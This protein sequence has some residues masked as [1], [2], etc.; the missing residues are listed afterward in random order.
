MFFYIPVFIALYFNVH[1]DLEKCFYIIEGKTF[2]YLLRSKYDLNVLFKV[3]NL[4]LTIRETLFSSFIES[5]IVVT[6][7]GQSAQNHIPSK[8]QKLD[9]NSGLSI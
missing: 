9:V 6:G 2:Q 4:F 3:Y 8:R 1:L 7:A 5:D